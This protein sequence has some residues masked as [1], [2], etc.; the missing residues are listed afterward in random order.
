[1]CRLAAY[2]GKTP[3][4]MADVLGKPEHSLI[5]QSRAARSGR[6]GINADGFGM[7][8]YNLDA[9]DEPGIFRSTQPA[10]NDSNLL[11]IANVIKSNCFLGHIRASTVGDVNQ[12]NCH[13]F[14]YQQ[15]SFVHNGTIRNFNNIKRALINRLDDELFLEIK[16]NTD[17]ECLFFLIMQYLKSAEA[18]NMEDAV[19][20]AFNWVVE[21]QSKHGPE[22]FSRL[23]IVLSD[24]N[25][26]IATRMVS[27]GKDPIS[28]FYAEEDAKNGGQDITIA[29]EE[30]YDMDDVWTE[31][32][33]NHYLLLSGKDPK[34][35]LKKFEGF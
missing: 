9:S 32:P 5:E 2:F 19:N 11:H 29:S 8:W 30:L 33:E 23:N 31:V 13:P 15:Y 10:W 27:E 4:I 34:I 25:H 22:D 35:E 12:N 18:K 24:G 21:E 20:L 16:G 17:S 7:S 28:L 26:M 3:I 6:F 14:S 1:M